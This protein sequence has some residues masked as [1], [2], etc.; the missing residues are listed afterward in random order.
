MGLKFFEIMSQWATHFREETNRK[1]V[2]GAT[3]QATAPDF[4]A[5]PWERRWPDSWCRSIQWS[6]GARRCCN[7]PTSPLGGDTWTPRRPVS[8][9]QLDHCRS[10]RFSK[11]AMGQQ[12]EHTWVG[13]V[14]LLFIQTCPS[15]RPVHG[16]VW[17]TR[18][19]ASAPA[20]SRYSTVSMWLFS[21]ASISGVLWS[22]SH[23]SK[24]EPAW[25]PTT[26][27]LGLNY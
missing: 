6:R 11:G 21:Q 26:P 7:G 8:G 17:L 20:L 10:G 27:E 22:S 19:L 3:T 2:G 12:E 24:F 15:G 5:S 1:S 23:M 14:E 25:H 16:L 13:Q 9:A 18:C 4:K